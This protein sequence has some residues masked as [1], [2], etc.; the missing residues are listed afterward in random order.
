MWVFGHGKR[1]REDRSSLNILSA[2]NTRERLGLPEL[3]SQRRV[4]AE[5]RL[6]LL[7]GSHLAVITFQKLQEPR[8][9]GLRQGSMK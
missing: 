4:P 9:A 2:G 1:K 6:K 7:S 5:L 3:E 8:R